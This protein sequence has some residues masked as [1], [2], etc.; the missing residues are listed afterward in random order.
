MD[1]AREARPLATQCGLK[2]A[3][4]LH[5]KLLYSW[6]GHSKKNYKIQDIMKHKRD[7]LQDADG[8]MLTLI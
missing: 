4:V 3:L 2:A 5:V 6:D 7:L 8:W 1:S